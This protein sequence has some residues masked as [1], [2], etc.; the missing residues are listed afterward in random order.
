[1]WVLLL[2]EPEARAGRIITHR[3]VRRAA[4]LDFCGVVILLPPVLFGD[5][6]L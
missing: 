2:D 1:M 3:A 4:G 5:I 6:E